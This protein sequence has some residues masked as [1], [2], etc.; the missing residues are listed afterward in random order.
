MDFQFSEKKI[1]DFIELNKFSELHDSKNIFFCKTD[2]ILDDFKLIESLDNEVILITGNSD[3][4]ITDKII[5]LLPNNVR[6]WFAQNAISN[7]DKLQPIPIGLENKNFSYRPE[8]GIGYEDRV[9]TKEKL[10]LRESLIPS[11]KKI[12][13]NF[14]IS[15]NYNHRNYVKEISVSSEHIDWD[16]PNLSLES[17][18]DKILEYES[19]ICPAGNGVDT[20]RLWEVLYS[21]KIP[22]T[23]KMGDYK[24]Y[25]LYEKLPIVILDRV[26]DLK[27]K[28]LLYD[29]LSEIKKQEY[30]LELLQCSY[31]VNEI[32][33]YL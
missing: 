9:T 11:N 14:N 21:K 33:K 29:K 1:N 15:T 12:Y 5:S 20:H 22:I 7:H 2:F 17:F 10:L 19:V 23:V 30:N 27:N 28:N 24:I 18:F 32:K 25:S 3:Y 8:H 26:E 4:P 16:E 13:S 6:V 31:W